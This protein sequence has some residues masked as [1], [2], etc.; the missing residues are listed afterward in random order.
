MP[1]CDG[2]LATARGYSEETTETLSIGPKTAV[3]GR[4]VVAEV[5]AE[6]SQ[7]VRNVRLGH[8]AGCNLWC[9]MG[10]DL[11]LEASNNRR[12]MFR[13]EGAEKGRR[14]RGT[15][16]AARKG[17]AGNLGAWMGWDFGTGGRWQVAGGSGQWQLHAI[18]CSGTQWLAVAAWFNACVVETHRTQDPHGTPDGSQP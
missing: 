9:R 11:A 14:G 2:G 5:V 12:D 6:W 18:A 7:S 16:K 13:P 4:V 3:P 8:K 10:L 17:W 1:S 15:S